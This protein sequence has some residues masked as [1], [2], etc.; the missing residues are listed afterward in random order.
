MQE[1]AQPG[2]YERD[3]EASNSRA[4]D[5]RHCR[6]RI[7]LP[8]REA[9]VEVGGEAPGGSCEVWRACAVISANIEGGVIDHRKFAGI[10]AAASSRPDA[11]VS[12]A[13][14]E[15]FVLFLAIK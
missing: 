4:I 14:L 9:M 1:R 8:L 7:T 6:C 3:K 15:V 11:V 12:V 2:P 10:S 13:L 5:N